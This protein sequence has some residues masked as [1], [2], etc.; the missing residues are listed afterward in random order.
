MKLKAAT[1]A[2]IESAISSQMIDF[3][4]ILLLSFNYRFFERL[5]MLTINVA[6]TFDL[7][8]GLDKCRRNVW[9]L[10]RFR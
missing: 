7:W 6:E 8:K 1:S 4:C 2:E 3:V 5:Y 10:K 9:P